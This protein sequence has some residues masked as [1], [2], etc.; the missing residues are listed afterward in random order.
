MAE[1]GFQFEENLLDLPMVVHQD[2][3]E[4]ALGV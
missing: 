4:I 3:D 2:F 1:Q